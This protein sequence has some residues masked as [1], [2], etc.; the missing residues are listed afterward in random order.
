MDFTTQ[1]FNQK[2]Q[3]KCVDMLTNIGCDLG[4]SLIYDEFS[5][6]L[7]LLPLVYQKKS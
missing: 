3:S 6:D 7:M 5:L 4:D 2:L 1:I